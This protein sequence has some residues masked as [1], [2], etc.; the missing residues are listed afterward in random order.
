M[1]PSPARSAR[2]PRL[3]C[4]RS[5]SL[6]SL[7]M[8][9][10]VDRTERPFLPLGD[11]GHVRTKHRLIGQGDLLGEQNFTSFGDGDDERPG[12]VV[13]ADHLAVEGVVVDRRLPHRFLVDLFLGHS[14]SPAGVMDRIRLD[15][16]TDP[17]YPEYE[18]T[19]TTMRNRLP[20]CGHRMIESS[21]RATTSWSWRMGF[22]PSCWRRL[23][24]HL[25]RS[26]RC[27]V[28]CVCTIHRPFMPG[29]SSVTAPSVR[30]SPLSRCTPLTAGCSHPRC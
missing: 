29:D 6:L 5:R 25:S 8:D 9:V 14:S 2:V 22:R 21:G 20:T 7:P 18:S 4:P 13:G 19:D 24:S 16:R 17:M 27:R 15:V 26:N 28:P 12:V 1:R 30:S 23:Y 10:V 11:V 3:P